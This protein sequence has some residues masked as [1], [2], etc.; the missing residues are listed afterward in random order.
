MRKKRS[1]EG[2]DSPG[3]MQALL[4]L[5]TGPGGVDGPW[6][7]PLGGFGQVSQVT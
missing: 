4:R 2:N 6:S 7:F 3:L 5:Q 1:R